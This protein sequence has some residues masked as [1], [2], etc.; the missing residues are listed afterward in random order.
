[1][2]RSGGDCELCGLQI[3]SQIHHRRPRASGGSRREDTNSAANLLHVCL[4]CHAHIESG[5][6]SALVFGLLLTQQQDPASEPVQ[7]RGVWVW[8]LPD[9][10]KRSA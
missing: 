1:M 8:L 9:G 7:L 4:T 3:A 5:R 10:S 2:E 6:T